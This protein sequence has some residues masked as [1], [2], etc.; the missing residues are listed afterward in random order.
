MATGWHPNDAEVIVGTSAG[1][2]V[3]STVRAGDLSVDSI[4]RP[5]E[6]REQVAERIR[7]QLYQRQRPGGVVRWVRRGLIP[8]L[9]KPGV[10]MLLG[11]PAINHAG[12]IADWVEEQTGP[13]AHE[14]PERPTVIVAF[15]IA[16]GSRVA[17]GTEEAPDVP[18]KEAVAA[19]S[20]VPIIFSP[21][22]IDGRYYVDGG[23]AS[24]THADLVLGNAA[25]LDLVLVLAPMAAD[26]GRDGARFYEGIFD[27]V[28]CSAL[29]DEL[30]LIEEAWPDADILVLRPSPMVLE[31]MRP[32]PMEPAGAVPT[33]V[34]TLASLRNKLATPDVW[35]VLDRHL[36]TRTRR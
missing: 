2:F 18:L 20:A 36:N 15:D 16:D 13:I 22:E 19:S 35:N 30:Q 23:V 26:E 9:R 12:G 11:T 1:S 21:Y 24:G 10:T 29:F 25:P 28:G 7:A 4:V 32:N 6:G 5:H 3:A 8:S 34:R 27:R 14:W 31:S 17:F 33:F